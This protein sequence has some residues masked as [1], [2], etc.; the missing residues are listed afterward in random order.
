[1]KKRIKTPLIFLAVGCLAALAAG[2]LILTGLYREPIVAVSAAAL[3]KNG[4]QA[5]TALIQDDRAALSD[6]LYGNPQLDELPEG[7]SE[8][9]RMIRERYLES[10]D[11]YFSESVYPTENG[12]SLEMT[13][14]CLDIGALMDQLKTVTPALLAEKAQTM[15]D[16]SQVYDETHQYRSE[17]LDAVL[18]EA[19]QLVLKEEPDTREHTLSL[20]FCRWKGQWKLVPSAQVQAMLAGFITE[21]R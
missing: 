13:L 17:F 6:C 12:V 10:L 21:G 19:V 15:E 11:Y 16:E 2:A 7:T 3:R 4:E 20:E 8:A 5:M 9:E 18:Q 14:R 1:M